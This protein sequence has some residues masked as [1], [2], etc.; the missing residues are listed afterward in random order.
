[1]LAYR[2]PAFTLIDAHI[3]MKNATVIAVI[4]IIV[5][6]I[7]DRSAAEISIDDLIRD[8]GIVEGEVAMRDWPR[9]NGARKLLVLRVS[10]ESGLLETLLPDAEFVFVNSESEAIDAASDVDAI[11]G[12]CSEPLVAAARRLVWIQIFSS[13]AERCVAL[14]GVA[15]G[16]ILLT[17]MQKMSAPVIGEHAI[18]MML[19]LSR[20]LPAF[21]KGMETGEWMRRSEAAGSMFPISGR[22]MLVVGLGGIG[23]ET[24]KRAAALGMRVVGIRNS[25]REGPPYVQYVGLPD[26]LLALA[27]Q[28]D[29]I[30]NALPLTDA[31]RGLLDAEFFGATR[32]GA[33]F[34]NV[35]RGGTVD[36][37]ALTA[38]IRNGQIGG[39]GLDVTDPEPLPADHP[40]WQFDNTIITPHVAGR[41]GERERHLVLLREN[42]RR[43]STGEPLLNVVDP[44]RGY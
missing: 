24:A 25:S 29:V 5:F 30:V 36:T 2:K 41:G 14:P 23:V 11:I 21:A 34:L 13:G 17:N 4:M 38:A 6:P 1:M 15:D 16:R 12:L 27:G 43:F 3:K 19:S 42:L 32:R 39:A 7:A 10:D 26:E 35:G 9:W 40:L 20:Q 33:L 31:T 37:D 18:A 44:E 28:A 8:T 22:T